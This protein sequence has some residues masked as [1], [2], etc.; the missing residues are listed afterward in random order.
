MCISIS[1]TVQL[2]NGHI[3][4]KAHK[5]STNARKQETK[6]VNNSGYAWNSHI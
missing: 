1:A 3:A 6:T 2:K 4:Y 5:A